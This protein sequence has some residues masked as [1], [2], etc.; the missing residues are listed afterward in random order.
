[1]GV[2]AQLDLEAGVVGGGQVGGYDR[3]GPPVVGPRCRRHASVADGDQ[4]GDAVMALGQDHLGVSWVRRDSPHSPRARRGT[5]TCAARP[6][7]RR[8]SMPA[9]LVVVDG[10]EVPFVLGGGNAR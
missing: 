6:A 5:R 10:I 7:S 9:P 4:L 3:R 8:S 2:A 1:M